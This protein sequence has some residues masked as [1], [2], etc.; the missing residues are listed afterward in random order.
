MAAANLLVMLFI[1]CSKS[2]GPGGDGPEPPPD[3]GSTGEV[4]ATLNFSTGN[5]IV[6]SVT[7]NN[8]LFNRLIDLA[9]HDTILTITG[10]IPGTLKQLNVRLTDISSPGTYPFVTNQSAPTEAYAQCEFLDL[11]INDFYSTLQIG[12]DPG[13][14]TVQSITSN[15]VSGYFNAKLT[16]WYPGRP[17]T[18]GTITVTN[19]SFK[20]SFKTS[21]Y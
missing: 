10:G 14:V 21:S 1:S 4:K 2:S 3:P 6:L 9:N 15:Y 18:G 16:N 11:S 12:T 19:G 13:S 20:G 7:G 5:T 8:T 17:D